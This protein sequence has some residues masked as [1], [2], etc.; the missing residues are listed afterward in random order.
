MYFSCNHIELRI[1]SKGVQMEK[2]F[3]FTFEYLA[4]TQ[5]YK[6]LKARVE[7]SFADIGGA[8]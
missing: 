7:C 8:K 3:V 6:G 4:V 5:V 2:N 1:F